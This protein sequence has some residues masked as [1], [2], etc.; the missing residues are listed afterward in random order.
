[1][2]KNSLANLHKPSQQ[3]IH[4]NLN[5]LNYGTFSNDFEYLDKYPKLKKQLRVAELYLPYNL[6][7]GIKYPFVQ[8]Y[9][10][11][12]NIPVE[13]HHIGP[14]IH[15]LGNRRKR[16]HGVSDVYGIQPKK[17]RLTG[18]KAL[19]YD[20]SALQHNISILEK[21]GLDPE[22]YEGNQNC[23]LDSI[24]HFDEVVAD[25]VKKSKRI[26]DN[27]KKKKE[28]Q[29][30]KTNLVNKINKKKL[31][32]EN[33]VEKLNEANISFCKEIAPGEA[34]LSNDER[35]QFIKEKK[36]LEMALSE[37]QLVQESIKKQIV[38]LRDEESAFKFLDMKKSDKEAHIKELYNKITEL[39]NLLVAMKGSPSAPSHDLKAKIDKVA[40]NIEIAHVIGSNDNIKYIQ[41]IFKI[42][43]FD[44]QQSINKLEFELNMPNAQD[45]EKKSLDAFL[46]LNKDS[47]LKELKNF[48]NLKKNRMASDDIILAM[49]RSQAFIYNYANKMFAY[50]CLE[51][52]NAKTQLTQSLDKIQDAKEALRGKAHSLIE[53][54]SQYN[55]LQ[56]YKFIFQASYSKNTALD[57]YKIKYYAT[58]R[59][60][61]VEIILSGTNVNISDHEN[62]CKEI[63]KT[64]DNLNDPG[65]L[66]L[67]HEYG[68]D[69]FRGFIVAKSLKK[70][71]FA[72]LQTG[73]FPQYDLEATKSELEYILKNIVQ[74]VAFNPDGFNVLDYNQTWD[75]YAEIIATTS[76]LALQMFNEEWKKNHDAEFLSPAELNCTPRVFFKVLF[77]P[78]ITKYQEEIST[79]SELCQANIF[80]VKSQIDFFAPQRL[81]ADLL[82]A[83]DDI[84]DKSTTRLKYRQCLLN[85]NFMLILHD[86]MLD[87]DNVKN[88]K[89]DDKYKKFNDLIAAILDKCV[90]LI[91]GKAI[92]VK[93]DTYF[94][95]MDTVFS[96][97]ENDSIK[98]INRLNA[99]NTL[100]IANF[101]KINREYLAR[102]EEQKEVAEDEETANN[103]VKIENEMKSNI[104]SIAALEEKMEY[105]KKEREK[106]NAQKQMYSNEA[107]FDIAK[108]WK[109]VDSMEDSS[110]NL[111]ICNAKPTKLKKKNP[112]NI[113]TRQTKS[114][115]DKMTR[116]KQEFNK[117]KKYISILEKQYEQKQDALVEDEV[118]AVSNV[119]GFQPGRNT[120]N[121]VSALRRTIKTVK[122]K[123]KYSRHQS[124]YDYTGQASLNSSM[125]I[126]SSVKSSRKPSIIKKI[127]E[128]SKTILDIVNYNPDAELLGKQLD[129][130]EKTLEIIEENIQE[131]KEHIKNN[132]SD[133]ENI[134]F[135]SGTAS[136]NERT[137]SDEVLETSA[138]DI[139]N[140][141]QRV[142]TETEELIKMVNKSVNK[143]SFSEIFAK[144]MGVSSKNYKPTMLEKFLMGCAR[145][146]GWE[147]ETSITLLK[148][149]FFMWALRSEDLVLKFL[150]KN[151]MIAD[152][153]GVVKKDILK[154]DDN[155]VDR[156]DAVSQVTPPKKDLPLKINEPYNFSMS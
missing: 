52:G 110:K 51:E 39:E 91:R 97:F 32:D 76:K 4:A 121:T 98:E 149:L 111:K 95:V 134:N 33:L 137:I 47:F 20:K 150:D 15:S 133:L 58:L 120:A 54:A 87:G 119:S 142:M 132:K 103:A 136:A 127:Q 83:L 41:T 100:L 86:Y 145:S 18:Y 152:V 151:E 16:E 43:V 40:E 3:Y 93:S 146:A 34:L 44:M 80:E 84:D 114:L 66:E 42:A 7:F 26:V 71:L 104:Q 35:G 50:G 69:L 46:K 10:S 106:L 22:N 24:E 55:D 74:I 28:L 64:I 36:E 11:K 141:S 118:N 147:S 156:F 77:E 37:S 154:I 107:V 59:K 89:S 81:K 6:P 102:L 85:D 9:N 73:D 31:K 29:N 99:Q 109:S 13:L 2:D 122:K 61:F 60:R 45:T 140:M 21:K 143:I 144:K 129:T 82:A 115:Y 124:F 53:S 96:K 19:S 75:S 78:F 90:N 48:I 14:K 116:C 27:E 108:L 38:A 56:K 125:L 1:M 139:V 30:Q 105:I 117:G 155:I 17:S 5:N 128:N 123:K 126:N 79:I 63:R 94:E 62:V 112:P 67:V 131:S 72:S 25:T 113:T 8:E 101:D 65:T 23:L 135:I 68:G 138:H 70:E 49:A 153:G 130:I 148:I 12:P 92:K 57:A 88:L